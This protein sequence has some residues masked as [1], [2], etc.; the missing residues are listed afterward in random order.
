MRVFA[1]LATALA[2]SACGAVPALA[3]DEGVPDFGGHANVGLMGFDVDGDGPEPTVAW[4][5]GTV[6][7]DDVFLTAAHCLINFPAG[8][9]FAVTLEPGAPATPVYRPGRIFDDFP[10]PFST[11]LPFASKAVLHPKFGGDELR[12]HDV[13]VLVFPPDTFKDVRPVELPRAGMLERLQLR[14]RAF[15]LVSYG[16]DP[17]WGNGGEPVIIAEGYRQTATAPFKRLTAAQLQ[18]DGRTRP[19]RAGR[20][21][22]TPARRSCSATRTSSSRCCRT[23]TTTATERSSGSGW[24]R[25]QSAGSWPTTST[26]PDAASV[27]SR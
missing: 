11:D 4:C 18:L 2:I 27:V 16:G 21:S 26:C 17:E 13:G 15:R 12:T 24:T 23:S 19:A 8:T 6:V 5:S 25:R 1:A 14:D 20:A 3:V 9:S 22:A 10:Y 7:S